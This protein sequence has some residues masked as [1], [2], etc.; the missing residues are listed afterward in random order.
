MWNGYPVAGLVTREGGAGRNSIL[1]MKSGI[2]TR[3]VLYDSATQGRSLPRTRDADLRWRSHVVKTRRFA[4]PSPILT[5][6][7]IH[8]NFGDRTFF[9]SLC[10]P[11]PEP[12]AM[13]RC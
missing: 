12:L 6:A 7:H 9:P 8:S 3:G 4:P 2:V 5:Q 1:T 13:L 10:I 11:N